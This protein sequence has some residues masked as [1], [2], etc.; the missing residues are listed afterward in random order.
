M[1]IYLWSLKD[2]WVFVDHLGEDGYKVSFPQRV[3]ATRWAEIRILLHFSEDGGVRTQPQNLENSAFWKKQAG[4]PVRWESALRSF[5]SCVL[6]LRTDNSAWKGTNSFA[7]IENSE[8]VSE[9]VDAEGKKP[10]GFATVS[11]GFAGRE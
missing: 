5:L 6:E 3:A 8:R 11:L 9:A 7:S 10:G 1:P 4:A 2:F